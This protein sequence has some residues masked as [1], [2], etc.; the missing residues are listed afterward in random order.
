MGILWFNKPKANDEIEKLSAALQ[1][2][3]VTIRLNAVKAHLSVCSAESCQVLISGLNDHDERVRKVLISEIVAIGE[4]AIP[5]LFNAMGNQSRLIR[6]G[7]AQALTNLRWTPDDDEIKV[8]YLFAQEAWGD[9]AGFEKKAIPYLI[10]VLHDEDPE[11][12]KNVAATIGIIGDS[13][14]FE[15][16]IL[17][18]NDTE[19][20]VR[21]AA[22]IALGA[23]KDVRALP[24]LVELFHNDS[25]QVRTAA[26]D[27]VSLFGLPA[28][29]TLVVALDDPNRTVRHTAI[30]ALGKISDS[31]V[32]PLL[33]AKLEDPH[34]EIR[35][36]AAASLGDIGPQA[37]PMVL[38]IMKRG[39]RIARHACLDVF[40]KNRDSRVTEIL[41]IVARGDDEQL[42]RKAKVVI[43]KREQF[44]AWHSAA[45]DNVHTHH[46]NWAC[47]QEHKAFEQL[48]MQEKDRVLAILKDDN[49]IRRLTA[50]LKA[51]NDGW[52]VMEALI[53]TIRDTDT[54]IRERAIEAI[55]KLENVPGNPLTVALTDKDPLIRTVAAR[56]LG[57]LGWTAAIMP[58]LHI[59]CSEKDREVRE[60]AI[61]AI[62]TMRNHPDLKIVVSE[63]LANAL[64]HDSPHIRLTAAQLLARPGAIITI[65]PLVSLLRD[66]V[67]AVRQS[68]VKAL[69]IIGKPAYP[70]LKLATTDTD[71]QVRDAALQALSRL[72]GPDGQ[73]VA[74]N[75]RSAPLPI[76]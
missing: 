21:V 58:L 39:S 36:S 9:I 64:T 31:R 16:L 26:A 2:P 48:G 54:T 65:E 51:V 57:K 76:P 56:N 19:T 47:R 15:P 73:T 62:K 10:G 68:A 34:R 67:L 46:G 32:I 8:F 20:E 1:N 74:K 71:P 14:G 29:D 18:L 52:P 75:F 24:N 72:R 17:C 7:A 43:Q 38:E 23:L 5:L 44:M 69:S 63:T 33:I 61:R 49:T 40:S 28:V 66:P 59:V 11:I 22:I 41:N 37:M 27:V 25:Q 6:H 55:D 13:D 60:T 30:K 53:V 45:N 3:D 70:A 4:S 12:R 50:I 42:A 35:A